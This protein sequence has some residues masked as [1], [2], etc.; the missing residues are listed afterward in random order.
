MTHDLETTAKFDAAMN[1]T[2][3]PQTLPLAKHA[4]FTK[5]ITAHVFSSIGR[6]VRK[7]VRLWQ[8]YRAKVQSKRNVRKLTEL[9]DAILDDMCLTRADLYYV[10]KTRSQI[11]PMTRLKLISA[12]RRSTSRRDLERR[13][14]YLSALVPAPFNGEPRSTRKSARKGH[15]ERMA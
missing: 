7:S 9:D 6:M 3:N 8:A 12:Q 13:A 2:A 11:L 4:G 10:L 1:C 15:D 5:S 14:Q